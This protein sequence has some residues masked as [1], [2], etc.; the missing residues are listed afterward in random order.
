MAPRISTFF[1][2]AITMYVDDHVPAHFHA[3]YN[4][5]EAMFDIKTLD[6]IQ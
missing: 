2:I 1:G 3:K 6:M 4:E 5:F